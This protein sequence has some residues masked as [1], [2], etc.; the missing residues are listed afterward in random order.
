M[1]EGKSR[2]LIIAINL[3]ER[4]EKRSLGDEITPPGALETD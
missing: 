3:T 1:A 4:R 2:T